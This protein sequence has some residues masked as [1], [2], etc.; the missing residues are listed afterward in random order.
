MSDINWEGLDIENDEKTKEIELNVIDEMQNEI[1]SNSQQNNRTKKAIELNQSGYNCAQ[2]I[3]AAFADIVNIDEK[4]ALKIAQPL[5]TGLGDIGEV[6]GAFSAMALVFGAIMGSDVPKDKETKLKL[7]GKIS[8]LATAF[9]NEN[10]GLTCN[11]LLGIG[12]IKPNPKKKSCVEYV[13]QCAEMLE[14][15]IAENNI[16]G[17]NEQN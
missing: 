17:E 15:Y 3:F 11:D 9:K 7:Y 5:G 1:I 13:R 12:Q 14:K 2:A 6:C 4:L 16:E 8:D 10:G